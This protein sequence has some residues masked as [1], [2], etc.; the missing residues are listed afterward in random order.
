MPEVFTGWVVRFTTG[1]RD[2]NPESIRYLYLSK[3]AGRTFGYQWV[4][5]PRAAMR[6]DKLE[7]AVSVGM[8]I[9]GCGIVSIEQ[10]VKD[11][12]QSINQQSQ[13]RSLDE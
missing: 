13:R 2:P 1:V 3:L 6:W 7:K 12:P 10:A 8:L 5:D 4:T 11:T 9:N